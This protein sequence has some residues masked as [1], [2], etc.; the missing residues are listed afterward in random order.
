MKWIAIAACMISFG[1]AA[2]AQ[3]DATTAGRSVSVAVTPFHVLAAAD[4]QWLGQALQEGIATG[5]QKTSGI[6]GIIVPGLAPADALSAIAMAKPAAA[7]VTV[8]GSVQVVDNQIRILG[9]IISTS[10]GKSLGT[11]RCDAAESG[12]FDAED[13]LAAEAQRILTA[14]VPVAHK[15]TAAPAPTIQ[16]VGPTVATGGGPR[17]G[18]GDVMSAITPP[19][20]HQDDYDRYYYYSADTAAAGSC[21]GAPF[22][23]YGGF[24]GGGCFGGGGFGFG[25]ASVLPVV[26][27]VH[28]W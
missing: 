18:S 21:Y 8:F 27:P 24:C 23:F 16:L 12:L 2:G 11:L 10:S 6:T 20:G 25:G 26:T 13:Q 22:P 7:D 4:S 17:Y 9:Q 28:G 15:T 19:P 1:F 14:A 5:I 3:A